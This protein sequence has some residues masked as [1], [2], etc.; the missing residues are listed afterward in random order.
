[1]DDELEEAVCR[2]ALGDWHNPPCPL[3]EKG[4]D[5]QHIHEA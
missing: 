4:G 2:A 1:L 3:L 5:N